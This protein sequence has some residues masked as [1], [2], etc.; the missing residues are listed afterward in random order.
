MEVRNIVRKNFEGKGLFS[1]KEYKKNEIVFVLKGE[2][3]SSPTRESIH[4]GNNKHIYDECG[5]F[6]N[7]SFQPNIRI[8]NVNVV[9]LQ[10]I[11]EDDEL[12]FNYNENEINM[13]SPFVVDGI[14][15]SGI[16]K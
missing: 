15:V 6:I 12:T 11:Q 9:A 13:A 1:T 7:H 4:I 8:D 10:D 5:I 3:F 2:I 14:T 16:Q